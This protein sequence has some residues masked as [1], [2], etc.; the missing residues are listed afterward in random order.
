MD[1]FA[2]GKND[3][4]RTNITKYDIDTGDTKPFKQRAYSTGPK[5]KQVIK[6]E[7][8]KM[9]KKGVIKKSKSPWSSP[10]VL[11]KKKDGEIRFCID[12]RKLNGYTKIDSHPLPRIDDTINALQG[13]QYFTTVDCA[14]G[15]WQVK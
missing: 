1:I 5:E 7:I 8:E 12:Y 3:L 9:L 2:K 4:G 15:Y 13:M 14:S 10:V 11:I 6:E